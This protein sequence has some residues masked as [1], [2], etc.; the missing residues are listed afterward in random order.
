MTSLDDKKIYGGKATGIILML[1][2]LFTIGIGITVIFVA[3]DTLLAFILMGLPTLLFGVF[4]LLTGFAS[5]ATRMEIS[6]D[7]LSIAAPA[8]RACPMPPVRKFRLQWDEIHAVRYRTEMYHLL[9]G[10]G[11]PFPV[12]VYAIDTAKGRILLGGKS[13]RVLAEAIREIAL[14]SGRGVQEEQQ[15]S[16]KMF[17]SLL[18][19]PPV[20]L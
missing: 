9:P 13:L 18:K 4:E 8:W 14:R 2:G 6:H 1:L 12:E 17:R 20:W 10:E 5:F 7:A 11:L 3:K 19:G 16:A 15:V